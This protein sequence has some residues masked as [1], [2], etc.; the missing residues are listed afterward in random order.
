MSI[1]DCLGI[2]VFIPTLGVRYMNDFDGSNMFGFS[3]VLNL[4]WGRMYTDS[5][6]CY[7][8]L[9]IEP[10]KYVVNYDE[11]YYDESYWDYAVVI[12]WLGFGGRHHDFNIYSN[13]EL[14]CGCISLGCRYTYYF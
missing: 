3:F 4:N 10:I 11:D 7:T 6:S 8:G 13:L 1:G 2:S 9:G 5:F 14:D 12:N